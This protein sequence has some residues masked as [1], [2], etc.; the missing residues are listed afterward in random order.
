MGWGSNIRGKEY[1]KRKEVLKRQK[2][3]ETPM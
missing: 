3:V 2:R 1:K